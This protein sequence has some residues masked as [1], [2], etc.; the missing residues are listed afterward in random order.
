MALNADDLAELTNRGTVKRAIRELDGAELKYTIDES[1]QQLIV[2]WSDGITCTFPGD[3]TLHDAVCSSGLQGIS[4]HIVRSVFAYQRHHTAK[5]VTPTVACENSPDATGDTDVS[6][7]SQSNAPRESDPGIADGNLQPPA[8]G[9]SLSTESWD[10]GKI[11]DD[12]LERQFRKA[13]VTRARKTYAGGVLVELIRG[14]KPVARFLHESCTVRF[15]VP[16]DVRYATADCSPSQLGQWVSLAV[17]SFRQLAPDRLAGLLAIQLTDLDVP[18]DALQSVDAILCELI[19]DGVSGVPATWAGR[20]ARLEQR[21][22]ACQLVWPAELLSAVQQEY[23][24]YRKHDA[25]FDPLEVVHLTGELIARCRAIRANTGAVPQLLIRGTSSDRRMDVKGGRYVGIGMEIQP[26]RHQTSIHAFLQNIDSGNLVTISRSFAEPSPDSGDQP[27]SFADMSR[28][29]LIRGVSLGFAASAQLLLKSGKQTPTGQLVLPRGPSSLTANPQSYQ[30]EQLLKAP[31]F[32]DS[33]TQL[34][35]RFQSLPP[36][37]LR[38]LRRTDNLHVLPVHRI[39]DADFDIVRQQ[40]IATIHD[41]AG[42]TAVL[43][44][45]YFSRGHDGFQQLHA[46][47]SAHAEHVKFIAGHVRLTA[48]TVAIS[49][50]AVIVDLGDQTVCINPWIR[51][52]GYSPQGPATGLDVSELAEEDALPLEEFI[53]EWRER[54][55]DVTVTGVAQ[56]VSADWSNCAAS[57]RRLGFARLPESLERLVVQLEERA[58]RVRWSG[59]AAARQVLQLCLL[60]RIV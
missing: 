8:N 37:W 32:V 10:P 7:D 50:V 54:L 27:K 38:P 45:P 31:L 56:A 18:L 9:S 47:L 11:S 13:A 46:V 48:G 51:H 3:G 52:P 58:Q 35:E 39:T 17:W 4:R 59:D 16:G 22:R 55:A 14:P 28:T 42:D 12:D 44:H 24:R 36:S 1:P 15:P 19:R 6:G 34:R 49:P 25:R 60:A 21:L 30:W 20:A 57:A 26:S 2:T 53:H 23:E 29:S 43:A 40:L 41:R 33:I 5:S